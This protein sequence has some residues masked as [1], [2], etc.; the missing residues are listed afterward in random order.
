MF[1][2]TRARV[3][4]NVR[5]FNTRASERASERASLY[6]VL[7]PYTADVC[8]DKQALGLSTNVCPPRCQLISRYLVNSFPSRL[9]LGRPNSSEPSARIIVFLRFSSAPSRAFLCH[10]LSELCPLREKPNRG[11]SSL[12]P[13]ELSSRTSSL[14]HPAA[15]K[16]IR[17]HAVRRTAR[18]SNRVKLPNLEIALAVFCFTSSQLYRVSR[19]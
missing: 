1:R 11:G 5:S 6:R 10:L 14:L 18:A 19:L 17:M 9:L 2:R 4:V 15:V 7:H 16:R 12:F 8:A 13:K 3:R